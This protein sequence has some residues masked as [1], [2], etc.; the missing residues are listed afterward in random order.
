MA[1]MKRTAQITLIE[2]STAGNKPKV[3]AAQTVE[4]IDEP[5]TIVS[6]VD[7]HISQASHP[8]T[9]FWHGGAASQFVGITNVT[10]VG[11]DGQVLV[12]GELNTTYGAPKDVTGGVKFFVLKTGA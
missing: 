2:N 10:I 4:V 11:S 6:S 5:D 12:D 1:R 3:F 7:R 9:I 8:S